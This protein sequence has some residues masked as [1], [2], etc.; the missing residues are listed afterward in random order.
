MVMHRLFSFLCVVFQVA[1]GK[2]REY[3]QAVVS[4]IPNNQAAGKDL[5]GKLPDS[6]KV[7]MSH[8]DKLTAL[9]QVCVPHHV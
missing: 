9:P 2:A 3:G 6:T 5:L 7:W 4:R 8:G 1:A